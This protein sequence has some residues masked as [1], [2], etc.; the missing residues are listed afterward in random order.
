MIVQIQQGRVLPGFFS[1]WRGNI[2]RQDNQLL[3]FPA[4]LGLPMSDAPT[5]QVVVRPEWEM[6][7][8]RT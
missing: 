1:W 3:P 8:T 7:W 6:H 5:R 2:G 4:T